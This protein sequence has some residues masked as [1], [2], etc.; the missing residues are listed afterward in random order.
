MAKR[1]V[2]MRVSALSLAAGALL[3]YGADTARVAMPFAIGDDSAPEAGVHAAALTVVPAAGW[4]WR[5]ADAFAATQGLP[6]P[7]A[8]GFVVAPEI[9]ALTAAPRDPGQGD[10]TVRPAAFTAPPSLS[11]PDTQPAEP[12]SD[13][14][15]A[16]GPFGLPCGLDVIA[17]AGAHAT[18]ALG[19]AAPC[20]A[21]TPLR[22]RHAGLTIGGQTDAVGLMTLDLPA[23]ESPAVVTVR[24]ADGTERQASVEIPD[25]VAYDRVALGWTGRLDLELHAMEAGAGWQE[26]GH[27]HPG[28][29]RTTAALGE[30][31]GHMVRLGTADATVQVYTRARHGTLGDAEVTISVD[32][33]VTV[34]NCSRRADAS[35]LRVEAGRVLDVTPIGFSY[36]TCDAVGDTLVLQNAMRDM[37]LAAN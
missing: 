32:A 33:P 4:E 28:A 2:I 23:L 7:A 3:V 35:I 21:E 6:L 24:L 30:R 11:V 14:D 31:A 27:V 9:D 8:A 20:H 25:L 36:P 12:P 15:Q 37:R 16:L 18:V 5:I 19:V 34:E 17:T 10:G 1:Q 13:T 26:P 22:I 29:M